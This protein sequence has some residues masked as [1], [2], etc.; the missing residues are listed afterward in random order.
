MKTPSWI[1]P[2]AGAA[3]L[4]GLPA[5]ASRDAT[6]EGE[7]L[8]P[9]NGK[10]VVPPTTHA[11]GPASYNDYDD[12]DDLDE[13]GA[14]VVSDPLEALNRATFLLNHGIYTVI[15]RPVADGYRFIVPK[16]LRD[17]IHNAYENVTFPGRMVNHA[18]Q[19]RLT[20]AGQELGKFLVNSTAGVGGLV[21]VSNQISWLQDVPRADTGQTFGTWGI[22]Q[23]PYLVLPI[24]G[25]STV[26]DTFG[27]AGD[28]VMNPL[29][30]VTFVF[31]G[32]TWTL[33]ITTPNTVRSLPPQMEQ[34]DAATRDALDRY[35]SA[36][37]AYIQFREA[38]VERGGAPDAEDGELL[39]FPD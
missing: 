20:R 33:A 29:S 16:L 22:G 10:T 7:L 1:F 26:R 32:A 35:L 23:G 9:P 18:L 15:L 27:I 4:F 39:V 34:Y 11:A 12:F 19:G 21:K 13:Y 2:L 5:C 28:Y 30:W 31:G 25:P 6:A 38:V 8:A 36:R 14:V 24:L 17:G 37:A 3:L